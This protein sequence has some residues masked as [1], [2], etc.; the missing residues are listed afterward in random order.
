M[1]LP[2]QIIPTGSGFTVK[3][4]DGSSGLVHSGGIYAPDAA[5]ALACVADLLGVPSE[6]QV[7]S[8]VLDAMRA[9]LAS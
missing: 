7:E 4:S 3:V 8:P 5:T 6:V 1:S 9:R 2:I